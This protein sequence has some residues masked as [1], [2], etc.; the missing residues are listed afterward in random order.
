[1]AKKQKKLVKPALVKKE[2]LINLMNKEGVSF[3]EFHDKVVSS[4]AKDVAS[5]DNLAFWPEFFKRFQTPEQTEIMASSII[6]KLSA[7]ETSHKMFKICNS[8]HFALKAETLL[9][10]GKNNLDVILKSPKAPTVLINAEKGVEIIEEAYWHYKS[11]SNLN[12]SAKHTETLLQK[13]SQ[14]RETL[15]KTIDSVTDEQKQFDLYELALKYRSANIEKGQSDYLTD[16]LVK[17]G[18]YGIKLPHQEGKLAALKH[19]EEAYNITCKQNIDKSS[20]PVLIAILSNIKDLAKEFGDSGKVILIAKQIEYFEDKFGLGEERKDGADEVKKDYL[21]IWKQGSTTDEILNIKKNIQENVLDKI[22]SA[23][24]EGKWTKDF[25]PNYVA[26]YLK[27]DYGVSGYLKED[28]LGKQLGDLDSEASLKIALKLC[29]EAINIGIMNSE[30]YNPLCAVIFVQKYPDLVTK[31]LKD[32]PEYFVDGSILRVSL[33]DADSHSQLLIGKAL[34]VNDGGYNSYFENEM[35]EIITD[36]AQGAILSPIQKIV[37]DQE[38]S[39]SIEANLTNKLSDEF[40]SKTIGNNL[41]QVPDVFN[42]IRILALQQ[43]TQ[44]IVDSGSMIFTPVQLFTKL[45]PNL[46]KRIKDSHEDFIG[47]EIVSICIERE[48]KCQQEALELAEESVGILEN[49]VVQEADQDHKVL[50]DMREEDG[51]DG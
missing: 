10:Q 28:W 35:K 9:V 36:R 29:F 19:S 6:A 26:G 25:M 27:S 3:A 8:Y 11:I 34:D 21:P 45:Y 7:Y 44:E 17:L 41:S 22:Q 38:W 1:M 30:T 23:A 18:E 47:D 13:L 2:S 43:I 49:A 20:A 33:L 15:Y 24:A 14:I 4:N 16:L 48:F 50:G 12:K 5:K 46:V 31:M 37:K 42:I 51:I 40:I 39:P 32:N